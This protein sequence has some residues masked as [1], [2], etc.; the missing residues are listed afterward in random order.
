MA[1]KEKLKLIPFSPELMKVI[2]ADAERCKRSFV[3]Q[4]EAVLTTYY[5]V[6]DISVNPKGLEVLGELS[7]KSKKKI[8]VIEAETASI[9]KKKRA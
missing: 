3:R 1:E 2:E 6:E 7:P 5:G 4:V 8:P 9:K